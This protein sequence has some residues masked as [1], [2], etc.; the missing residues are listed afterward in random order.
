MN[1]EFKKH[2]GDNGLYTHD[3]QNRNSKSMWDKFTEKLDKGWDRI[4]KKIDKLFDDNDRL[5]AQ[6]NYQREHRT[7]TADN[8]QNMD[9]WSEMQSH[10]ND[11]G[12]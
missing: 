7:H 1:N 3:T 4:N 11:N 9:K 6:G 2:W 10:F 12:L 8:S 5:N